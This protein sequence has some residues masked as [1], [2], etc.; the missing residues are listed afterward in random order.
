MSDWS[1]ES[2]LGEIKESPAVDLTKHTIS[3]NDAK[4]IVL[5]EDGKLMKVIGDVKT[6]VEYLQAEWDLSFGLAAELANKW[7]LERAKSQRIDYEKQGKIPVDDKG[8]V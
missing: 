1:L 6:V 4:L 5:M 7:A 3:Y 2:P 8:F